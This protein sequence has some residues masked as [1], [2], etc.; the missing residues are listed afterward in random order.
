VKVC[1]IVYGCMRECGGSMH[2]CVCVYLYWYI[3]VFGC[4]HV[5]VYMC[6]YVC[7]IMGMYK[8]IYMYVCNGMYIMCIRVY[9]Y[10]CR[11]YVYGVYM[12]DCKGV[13]SCV[14]MHVAV[15]SNTFVR[16][17]PIREIQSYTRYGSN[18]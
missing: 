3:L 11:V 13:R 5:C 8:C 7:M 14:W 17:R 18:T 10:V 2:P 6:V 12:Y 1:L 16:L 15:I 9:L 4:L